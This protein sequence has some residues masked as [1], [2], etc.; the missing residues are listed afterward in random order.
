MDR[1]RA[2]PDASGHLISHLRHRLA[3][4]GSSG[5]GAQGDSAGGVVP[6]IA[7]RA[8]SCPTKR[9]PRRCRTARSPTE[10]EVDQLMRCCPRIGTHTPNEEMKM[11]QRRCCM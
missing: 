6:G 7:I 10:G 3:E 2:L 4:D 5:C 8:R 9:P 11:D 1:V